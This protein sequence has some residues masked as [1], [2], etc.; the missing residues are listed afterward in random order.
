MRRLVGRTDGERMSPAHRKCPST[1]RRHTKRDVF[2]DP[3][4]RAA[5]GNGNDIVR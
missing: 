4:E 5:C 3:V 2:A 1:D